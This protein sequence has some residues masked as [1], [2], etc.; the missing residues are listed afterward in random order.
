MNTDEYQNTEAA[1]L[2]QKAEELLKSRK[3]K[4]HNLL[5]EAD[6]LKHVHELEVHQIE[7]ELQNEELLQ[8][9]ESLVAY[10]SKFDLAM[11]AAKMSW[12][13]MDVASGNVTFNKRKAD[14][15]GFP[16]ENFKHY[17]DFTRLVHPEDYDRMMNSM[18]NHLNGITDKYE[19]EYRIMNHLGEY[20]WTYD[21]GSIVKRDTSGKPLNIVGLVINITENKKAELLLQESQAYFKDMF[22]ENPS[23]CLLINPETQQIIDANQSACEFYGYSY[24][25]IIQLEMNKLTTGSRKTVKEVMQKITN[26]EENHFYFKHKKANGTICDI[27]LYSGPITKNGKFLIYSIIHDISERVKAQEALR[28]YELKLKIQVAEKHAAEL[29]F[30]DTLLKNN[31]KTQILSLCESDERLNYFI[32]NVKDYAIIF[33]DI[34]GNIVSWNTGAKRIKQYENHEIIGKNLS[35]FYT[36]EDRQN[37]KPQYLLNKAISDG[38]VIDEGWRVK[39]D[40]TLYWE[41]VTIIAL[42][43]NDGTHFG[44]AKIAHDLTEH[45][46]TEITLNDKKEKIELQNE[47]LLQINEE[48][49]YQ[50]EEK[51]KRAA[52]L[53]IANKELAYQNL[54]KE[55]RAAELIIA[56]KEL[57]FQ[58]KEKEK[59]AAE[60]SVAN[61]ELAYQNI[62]KENRAEELIIANTELEKSKSDIIKLYEGLEQKVSERTAQFNAAKTEAERANFSKSEFLSRMSHELRTPMNSILGFAQLINRG[63][64]SP[65]HKKGVGHIMKSG[66]HLLDLINEVL[67]LSRIESGKLTMSIE[68]VQLNGIILEIMDVVSPMAASQNVSLDFPESPDNKLFIK[69][70]RQRL[71][72]VLLNLIN[73]AVKFNHEGGSVKVEVRCL[74]AVNPGS[75]PSFT[76]DQLPETNIRISIT[77]TGKGVAENDIVKLFSAFQRVGADVSEVEGTGLGLAVSKKLMDAMHGAIGVESKVGIGSVFYIELPQAEGQ[78]DRHENDVTEPANENSGITGTV[79]YIE[80]NHS[81]VELV[82]QI[83]ETNLPLVRLVSEMFGKNSVKLA[84]EYKPDL[85]LLDLDLPD[86]HGNIVL[87]QLKANPKTRNIPVVVISADALPKQIEQMLQAGAMDYLTKPFDVDEFIKMVENGIK[88]HT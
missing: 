83:L 79:L 15:I 62:E 68:P 30:A 13:E 2:R 55:K 43:K 48:L 29:N 11:D 37:N 16:Q 84:T 19:V 17:T 40:G 66:K 32:E 21:L 5:S 88:F 38:S 42:R 78:I 34:D 71:K 14:M 81:N 72:Q 12:W 7:L 77:D 82:E 18:S 73:N 87:I 76:S 25:Q 80:D 65:T 61:S 49:A 8:V 3:S 60:L 33:F 36:P 39:K 57:A 1:I 67:D 41:S 70:D 86:I 45:R 50:N 64:L 22:H 20:I 23:I 54:E 53:I 47:E 10:I 74:E 26:G 75:Q 46:R 9:K 28:N 63:E 85:I 35:V 6:L 4:N 69:A 24:T 27:E 58:N 56:N 52:E 44:F 31:V 59:R 51:E